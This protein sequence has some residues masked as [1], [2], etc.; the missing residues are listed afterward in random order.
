MNSIIE[1]ED[2][3]KQFKEK[4]ALTDVNFSI[5]KGE[6]FGLVG[7]SGVGKTTTIKLLT[8]QLKPSEGA[9]RVFGESVTGNHTRL[10]S[11]MGIL[12]DR[13][14]LYERLSLY[15]NLRF[16]AS[17]YDRPVSTIEDILEHV[18]LASSRKAAYKNL[19]K[20]MKQRANLAAALIHAPEILILDEPTASLDPSAKANV[21]A[22]LRQLNEQGSTIFLTSHDMNEIESLCHRVAFMIDGTIY[23]CDEP[24]Q[25]RSMYAAPTVTVTFADGNV[26]TFNNSYT[27]MTSLR[28]AIESRKVQSLHSDE[29][30]L[31]D[32]FLDVTGRKFA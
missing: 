13:S 18:G 24:A 8:D 23:L 21:H 9:I 5:K 32:I 30:S 12:S 1:F 29:P 3:H 31:T 17:L 10:L 14:V 15:D 20:G 27:G 22:F 7:P 26:E 2:V 16:L 19:S 25:I 6:I 4:K 28:N 11:K